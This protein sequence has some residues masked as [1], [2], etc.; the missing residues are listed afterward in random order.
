MLDNSALNPGQVNSFAFDAAGLAELQ[1]RV[2]TT[3]KASFRLTGMT[4][5]PRVREI[6]GWDGRASAAPVLRIYYFR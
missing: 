4:P 6:F 1:S 2:S 3:G 5:A